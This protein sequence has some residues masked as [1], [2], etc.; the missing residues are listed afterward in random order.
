MLEQRIV[1]AAS[2]I[3]KCS[4]RAQGGKATSRDLEALASGE[5][6]FAA[7]FPSL[8]K[9]D[10]VKLAHV[11]VDISSWSLRHLLNMPNAAAADVAPEDWEPGWKEIQPVDPSTHVFRQDGSAV[12]F[13]EIIPEVIGEGELTAVEVLAGFDDRGLR[14]MPSRRASKN[15][16]QLTQ[17]LRDALRRLRYVVAATYEGGR[18]TFLLDELTVPKKT[19]PPRNVNRARTG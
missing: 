13:D 19:V 9:A 17:T 14:Y 3:V 4:Y 7:V 15:I 12:S 6:T 16:K 5:S 2:R 10:A 8:S 11:I 18:I 1:Q